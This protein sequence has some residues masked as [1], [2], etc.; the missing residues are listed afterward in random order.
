MLI[1]KRVGQLFCFVNYELYQSTRDLKMNIGVRATRIP[2]FEQ[3]WMD[4]FLEIFIKLRLQMT[5]F[6]ISW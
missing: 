2:T 3:I 4:T 5:I 6:E 1:L